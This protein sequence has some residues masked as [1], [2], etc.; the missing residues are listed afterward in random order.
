MLI[1]VLLGCS[2]RM[3]VCRSTAA[4]EGEDRFLLE[5]VP[6]FVRRSCSTFCFRVTEKRCCVHDADDIGVD[7]MMSARCQGN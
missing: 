7:A 4:Q 1:T 2:A 5:P 6:T 3:L